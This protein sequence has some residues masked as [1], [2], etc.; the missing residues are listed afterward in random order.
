MLEVAVLGLLHDE[1]LHGYEIKKRLA[2]L[3]VGASFGSLYPALTRLADD[4]SVIALDQATTAAE[5][6]MTGS[7]SGERA[8]LRSH[9]G[10]ARRSKGG[11]R[12]QAYRITADGRDRLVRKLTEDVASDKVFPVQVAFCRHLNHESRL[13]LFRRRRDTLAARLAE[14]ERRQ[15]PWPLDRY[16]S[17]LD[18]RGDQLI[19][20]DLAWLDRLIEDELEK[21]TIQT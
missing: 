16:V 19:I 18:E 11:R 10:E 4:G 17:S 20:N 14:R 6:P 5:P 12:R 1:D 21:G 3:D 13:D 9:G 7:L 8:I 15:A 2:E